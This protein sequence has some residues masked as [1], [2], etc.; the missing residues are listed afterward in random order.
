MTQ[1]PS[2]D[3]D[4]VDGADDD[5][6]DDDDDDGCSSDIG[7]GG[8]AGCHGDDDN[9]DD[10]DDDDDDDVMPV[11]HSLHI[12]SALQS[13]FNLKTYIKTTDRDKYFLT[14]LAQINLFY[15]SG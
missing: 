6:D 8:N 3:D 12:N 10:D 9:G 7:G 4:N 13:H 2:G 1:S 14:W 5:D 15:D 11:F